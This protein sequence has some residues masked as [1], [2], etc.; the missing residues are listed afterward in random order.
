MPFVSDTVLPGSADDF[1][2]PFMIDANGLHGRLV[3]LGP[4]L[5]APLKAH[6]YPEPVAVLLGEALAL[7]SGLSAGLK[8]DGVFSIQARGDGP[9]KLLVADV[10]TDGAIRGFADVRDPVPD[11]AADTP[12]PRLIG[13]GRLAF[14]VDQGPDTEQHQGIVDLQGASL[15]DC[16]HHYFQQ[17]SQYSAAVKLACHFDEVQGW[18]GGALVLQRLPE[19]ERPFERDRLEEAW[20]TALT[21]MGSCT[22]AELC[23]AHI[24][25]DDL[26]Y[27][28]F[29]EDGVR[30]FPA[31]PLKF[32]CKCSLAR[33]QAAVSMLSEEEREEMT[34]DGKIVVTCQFCNAEQVFDPKTL[35][36]SHA[37]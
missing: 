34:I 20:R 4:A 11:D 5:N 33:M 24:G 15:A 13:A 22:P 31:R 7:A 37:T 14:T 30:V 23:D 29:H 25:A 36:Q 17:S 18:R 10:T 21:L 9:V 2:R 3:R 32:S 27:R 8:F 26:L 19:D 16:V 12:I 35:S 1:I 6:D 28:L